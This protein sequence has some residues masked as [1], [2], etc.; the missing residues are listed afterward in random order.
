MKWFEKRNPDVT[1]KSV[2]MNGLKGVLGGTAPFIL[3]VCL[4]SAVRSDW[5]SYLLE[6]ITIGASVGAL[7]EWYQPIPQK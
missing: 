1:L 4:F 7:F 5:L 3:A 2:A 6:F